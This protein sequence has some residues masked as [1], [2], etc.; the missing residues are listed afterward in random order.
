MT[1]TKE[2]TK[3]IIKNWLEQA[4]SDLKSA[5]YNLNGKRFDVAAYLSHQSSEKSLKALYIKIHNK[6]WKTHDLIKLAEIVKAPEN[7]IR[8]CN[9]LN[10]IYAEDRYPDYSDIIPAKKFEEKEVKDFLNK[11]KEVVKWTKENPRL[12]EISKNSK[13]KTKSKK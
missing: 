7:I 9:E 13:K 10:P 5:E 4:E 3:K 11:A 1:S 2:E 12:S 6:L 8:I